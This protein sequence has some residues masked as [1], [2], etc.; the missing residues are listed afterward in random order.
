M[1]PTYY[2]IEPQEDG[3]F[4]INY[5]GTAPTPVVLKIVPRLNL[6]LLTIEGLTEEP[7]KFIPVR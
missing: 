5:T 2:P 6:Q 3:S 7:L 1:E 4:S